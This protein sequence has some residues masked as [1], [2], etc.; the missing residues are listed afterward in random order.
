MISPC[1]TFNDHEGSTKSYAYI[2]EHDVVLHTADFIHGG[3]EIVVD[4]EPGTLQDI[5]LDDGS[6]VLLRKLE[7]E[8]DATDR[9]GALRMIHE[10]RGRGELVTGLSTSIRPRAI[11]ASANTCPRTPLVRLDEEELRM[12]RADWAKLMEA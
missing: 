12:S 4:Y 7:R 8:Y 5:E 11:S 3:E 9:I 10:T 2:K 1:V 6:H